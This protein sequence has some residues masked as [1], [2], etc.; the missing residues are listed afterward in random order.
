MINEFKTEWLENIQTSAN[1]GA[2][3]AIDAYYIYRE[4]DD[5]ERA[6]FALADC[7]NVPLPLINHLRTVVNA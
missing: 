2:W 3:V 1:G 4:K 5:A 6:L 7:D